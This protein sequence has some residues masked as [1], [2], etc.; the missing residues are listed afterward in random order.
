[1]VQV[2]VRAEAAPV[3]GATVNLS[4]VVLHTDRNGV[5]SHAVPLGTLKITV[6]KEGFLSATTTLTVDEVHDWPVTVKLQP[7]ETVEEEITVYATRT[8]RR[9]QDSPLRVEVLNREEI[10]E[11]MMMTPGDIV[12][13]L[14]EMGGLRVQSASPSLGAASVRIQGMQGRYTRFL[15]DGLPL[16]GQQGAGLGLLQIPPMD[17]GQVEVIKGA[18]SALYG[19]G[20]MAGVVNLNSRRPGHKPIHEFLVNRSTLGATDTTLFLASRLSP[21][22]SGTV[23][24]GGHWQQSNDLDHDGWS[25]L[26]GYTR[27]VMRPRL[28]WDGGNGKTALLTGGVTYEDRRGGT[29]PG[30][31]LPAT[32]A[33]YQES[34]DTRRYDIGGNTQFIIGQRYVLTSRF[35]VSSQQHRHQF[36]E[37]TEHDSHDMLFGETAIRGSYRRNTWVA[38]IAVE[39]DA[40][41]P[42]EVSRFSYTYVTPG[43]FLQDD[44]D[45]TPWLSVSASGRAD[46]HNKYGTFLSPRVSALFRWAGWISRISAGQG[47]FAPSP[48]TEETEAAG[49]SRLSIPAPLVAERGRSA[50]ID[51]T[52]NVGPLSFTATLFGATI[53]HAIYVERDVRYQIINLMRPINN[54][55][56]ELLGTWRKAPFSATASYTYVKARETES[57]QRLDVPLT[58]RQ[59]FGLVGV[60]DKEGKGR[61]GVECYYTGEQRLEENPFRGRSR[62]YVI[63]GVMGERRVGKHYRLF[64]NLENLT[65]IR[66]TRWDSLLRPGRAPDGRWA[67]DAWAPLDGRGV[68]GGVRLIF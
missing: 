25:D 67:V 24:G 20:A 35:T 30:A 26:A 23:L 13:M 39:R 21:H 47:F 32:G 5:I 59:S 40:Y 22:W 58:P 1:M 29:A 7:Q 11:K 34:L 41:R 28:Y 2:E 10:E 49:L 48:L 54:V 38:G 43:I 4:G 57:G 45:I 18:A 33:P 51:V 15:S 52:R 42:R 68:N 3:E 60:W 9:L 46:F 36:G 65:D 53:S 56:A 31:V 8:D 61:V 37:V 62:A 63:L 50:S 17:L 19:A 64:L 66:Q 6:A 44:I 27:G 12:M 14:N 16:F 55:G